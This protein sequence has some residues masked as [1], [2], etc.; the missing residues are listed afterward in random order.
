M[1]V[2]GV[3]RTVHN[4]LPALLARLDVPVGELARRTMLPARVLARLRTPHAN[5]PFHT[6]VCIARALDVPVEAIFSLPTHEN[7]GG[8]G[9]RVTRT[10]LGPLLAERRLSDVQVARAARLDRAHV[11]RLKNGRTRPSVRTALAIA[12]A[13]GVDVATVFPAPS[14]RRSPAAGRGRSAAVGGLGVGSAAVGAAL[15]AEH[16]GPADVNRVR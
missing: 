6:A 5:P 9:A 3:P 7:G 11:N 13:L 15:I 16:E 14:S 1:R 12:A 2:A 4:R 10:G 8:R